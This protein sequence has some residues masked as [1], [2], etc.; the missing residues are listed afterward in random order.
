MSIGLP[1]PT[2]MSHQPGSSSASCRATCESPE[3]A[4]QINTALSRLR[5]ELPVGLKGHGHFRQ[6]AAKLQRQRLAEDNAL[7]VLQGLAGTHAITAIE[8]FGGHCGGKA[9]LDGLAN[10]EQII[11]TS[12]A[13]QGQPSTSADNDLE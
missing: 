7:G 8:N 11:K 4:W 12:I 2:T 13:R 1:G 3:R 9:N 5:V 10:L 6:P